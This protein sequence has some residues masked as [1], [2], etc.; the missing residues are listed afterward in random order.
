MGRRHIDPIALK[1]RVDDYFRSCDATSERITLKNGMTAYYQIPY[2]LAGLAAAAGIDRRELLAMAAG[3]SRR[4]VR[5]ILGDALRRIERYTVER[6]L[7][8]ELQQ[9]AAALMLR[10]LGYGAEAEEGADD[11]RIVIELDDRERWGD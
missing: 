9:S 3:T 10:E 8:G 2:T 1:Q 11:R 6:A 4:A 7:L 5:E